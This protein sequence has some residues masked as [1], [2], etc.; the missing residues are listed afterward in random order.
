[1]KKILLLFAI[2]TQVLLAQQIS[3]QSISFLKNA[4][5]GNNF[6]ATFS[7]K[8]DYLLTTTENYIG[9]KQY[10][11]ADKN[12]KVLSTDPGAGY[13]VQISDDGNTIV[14]KKISY[15]KNL[16]N[17]SLMS[18]SRVTGK[19][20]QLAAPTREPITPKFSANKPQFVK[21]KTLNRT[22]IAIKDVAP[23]ICIENQKMVLYNGTNRVVITPNGETASYIW[24]SVSPDRKYIAYTVAGKG[25]FV[26][27]IDG[28][29]PVSLGKL[30]APVWLNNSWI[31]GMDDK[32]NGEKMLSS[33]LVAATIDG[34][35]RQTLS[36]PTGLM[37]M[38]PAASND[39]S[40]IAFN[41]E[42]GELYLMKIQI[43]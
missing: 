21:G 37:A 43:K 36:T 32:D 1:M 5:N 3:I 15:V 18:L 35:V 41:T 20:T 24:P 38:Y 9:I 2:S 16:R 22:N 6:H 13:G 27:K 26:S 31:V 17:T 10:N 28:S 23:V 34:K 33:N 12:I 7:P 40:Q 4:E 30:N 19:Q 14:Y 42:K 11:I 29:N 25:T 8:G 39:G